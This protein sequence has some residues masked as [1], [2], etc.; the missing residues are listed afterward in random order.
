V[1]QFLKSDKPRKR[2]NGDPIME[3][4]A[5][6]IQTLARGMAGR[7]EGT[8]RRTSTEV[9]A[10]LASDSVNGGGTPQPKSPH[11]R[12]PPEIHAPSGT[13]EGR[14]RSLTPTEGKRRS[15][16]SMNINRDSRSRSAP[17]LDRRHSWSEKMAS[18]KLPD[19]RKMSVKETAKHMR[20]KIKEKRPRGKRSKKKRE[21]REHAK[22]L[23]PRILG[24]RK[25]S[26]SAPGSPKSPRF[27]NMVRCVCSDINVY[28][29]HILLLPLSFA[30]SERTCGAPWCTKLRCCHPCLCHIC[31]L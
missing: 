13:E 11:Q 14:P 26:S 20:S 4:M 31:A 18:A 2:G 29:H 1:Q 6:K 24:S 15:L 28:M 16:Q 22:S 12:R 9:T 5:L 7:K 30:L 27:K 10:D 23:S 17:S 21:Q 25:G 19:P 3:T 8:R